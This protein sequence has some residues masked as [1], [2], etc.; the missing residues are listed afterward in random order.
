[1]VLTFISLMAN[2]VG[3]VFMCLFATG[4]SS[5]NKTSV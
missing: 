5:L 1:M 4:M 2:D 3:R